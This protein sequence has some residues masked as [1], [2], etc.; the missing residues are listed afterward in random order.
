MPTPGDE[1]AA[2]GA[3]P[4]AVYMASSLSLD[5][6]LAFAMADSDWICSGSDSPP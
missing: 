1:A 2:D 5:S 6:K 4:L 3:S